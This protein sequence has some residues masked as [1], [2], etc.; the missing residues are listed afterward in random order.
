MGN[1]LLKILDR[2]K[3][4]QSA[5]L[6]ERQIANNAGGYAYALDDFARMRRFLFLGSCNG[7]YYVTEHDLTTENVDAITRCIQADGPRVVRE[8]VEIST[9]GRAQKNDPALFVLAL[10]AA[11]GSTATRNAAMQALPKVARI[12]THLFHFL[13][14][15]DALRGWGRALRSGVGEWYTGRSYNSLALQAIKY[16]QRDGWSHRDA[17]RLSHPKAKDDTQNSILHYMAQGWPGVGAEPHPAEALRLIWAA[18]RAAVCDEAERLQLIQDYNL[19]ME[20]IPTEL[21]TRA[22]YET[23]LPE[24]PIT[25][26]I[27]NLGTLSRVGAIETGRYTALNLVCDRLTDETVLKT[28]RVHPFSVL[29]AL[30]TYMSGKGVRGSG[31]WPVIQKVVDALEAAFAICFPNVEPTGKRFV[32]GLD[33]SGSMGSEVGGLPNVSCRLASAAMALIT[34]RT[35]RNVAAMA[36]TSSASGS[37]YRGSDLKGFLPFDIGANESLDSICTRMGSLPFGGTDCALPMI[38]ALKNRVEADVFVVY[39]DSETWHGDVHPMAALRDYRQK[40]GI[41]ARLVVVGMT[42]T[43]FSIADP[44]DAGTLDI[45]GLDSATPALISDFAAGRV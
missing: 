27:R 6:D 14:Y 28:G 10:C 43:G 2:D 44:D 15:V 8:V 13:A 40:M 30:R 24:A 37:R 9:S 32:L 25:W 21:R 41:P 23:L 38:W 36:F 3:T 18:E 39:T 17:L 26:L 7:T 31:E 29:V 33:V 12:G 45:V 22:V 19:P 42:S 5:P 16:R 35:E 20:V 4:P 11:K 1:Y 34:A